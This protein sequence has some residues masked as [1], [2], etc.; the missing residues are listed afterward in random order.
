MTDLPSQAEGYI[1]DTLI[2][3]D[4]LSAVNTWLLGDIPRTQINER[5]Y[6]LCQIII[7]PE[8]DTGE[9]SVTFWEQNYSGRITF[10]ENQTTA[11]PGYKD[12]I[13]HTEAVEE[14]IRPPSYARIRG[15]AKAARDELRKAEHMTMGGLIVDSEIVCYFRVGR[16]ESGSGFDTTRPNTW[17]NLSSIEFF[18]TTQK[19][20]E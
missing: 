8:E 13:N 5:M 11:P 14:T 4:D 19:R 2:A 10:E 15:Y 3:L 20:R 12:F 17:T 1:R 18:V 9:S 16:I 6:P 7:V